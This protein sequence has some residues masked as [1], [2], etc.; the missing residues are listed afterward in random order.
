MNRHLVRLLVTAPTVFTAGIVLADTLQPGRYEIVN[1][2]ESATMPI[3]T[4]AQTTTECITQQDLDQGAVGMVPQDGQDDGSC[5][6]ESYEMAGGEMTIDMMCDGPMGVITMSGRGTYDST[7]YR[8]NS[9]VT[10]QAVGQTMQV[11]S[12]T[13]ATRVGGC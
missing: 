3:P 7:M 6:V 4:T 8:I 12:R 2:V 10:I 5:E 9:T 13:V 11:K 1:T